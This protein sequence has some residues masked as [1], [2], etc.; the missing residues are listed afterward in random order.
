MTK[1][2]VCK[3]CGNKIGLFVGHPPSAEDPL[4]C[5]HCYFTGKRAATGYEL[6]KDVVEDGPADTLKSCIGI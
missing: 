4:L 2:V 5:Q 1:A 3:R 6:D